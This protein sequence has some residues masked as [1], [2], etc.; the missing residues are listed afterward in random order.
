[1]SFAWSPVV[2]VRPTKSLK[3]LSRDVEYRLRGSYVGKQTRMIEGI[4]SQAL[5]SL[6][7]SRPRISESQIAS[8]CLPHF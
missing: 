5:R 1:M 8:D 6:H 7:S 3:N 2:K 4:F